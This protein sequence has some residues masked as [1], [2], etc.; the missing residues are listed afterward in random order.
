MHTEREAAAA[1]VAVVL[2]LSASAEI[3][4]CNR[5]FSLYW[6]NA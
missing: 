3:I 1:A 5:F 6:E 4:F 2:K